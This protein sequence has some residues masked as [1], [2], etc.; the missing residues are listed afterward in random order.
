MSSDAETPPLAEVDHRRIGGVV[1]ER[2]DDFRVEE[3][4]L[5]EPRGEGEHVYLEVTREG[6][7]TRDVQLTLAAALGVPPAAVGYA[8]LKDKAGRCTQRFSI[9]TAR[10]DAAAAVAGADESLRVRD[11][12]RHGNKLRRGHLLGNRFRV[13]VRGAEGPDAVTH[14]AGIVDGL[15]AHGVP[16]WFGLQRFGADRQNASRGRRLIH[17]ARGPD[18]WTASVWLSAWQAELFNRWL[19]ARLGGLE[20]VL[21]GDV[22]KKT[23]TGG[24]FTVEDA[25][26]EQRRLDAGEIVVTGPLFGGRMREAEGEAGEMERRVL[27]K[28]GV[29]PARLSRL[30]LPGARRVAMLRPADVSVE[31]AEGGVVV[32]FSLPKGSYATTVLREVTG[33]RELR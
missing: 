20:R 18:R 11:L 24:L 23:D 9:A 16:N 17:G 6:R 25:A 2:L 4:P 26:A 5:Y 15:A 19:L 32:E 27:M 29:T 10:E 8:G 22:V 7:T 30:R 1:R 33:N 12:G 31:A 14:A 28:D 3:I 21:R 13:V